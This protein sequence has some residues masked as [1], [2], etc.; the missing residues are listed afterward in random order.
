MKIAYLIAAHSYPSSLKNLVDALLQNKKRSSVFIHID[1]KTEINDF[2]SCC[3]KYDNVQFVEN[4]YYVNWSSFANVLVQIELLKSAL[5]INNFDRFVFLSG[6]DYPVFSND[7]ISEFFQKNDKI[8]FV[9]GAELSSSN[10][11]NVLWRINK[12]HLFRDSKMPCCLRRLMMK[13]ARISQYCFG[14]KKPVK[15]LLGNKSVDVF[16][17][18]DW[19]ALTNKCAQMVL[20]TFKTDSKFVN[21]FKATFCPSEM[22]INTLVY[23][24]IFKPPQFSWNLS[25]PQNIEALTPLHFLKYNH[26]VKPLSLENYEEII[27]S[28]KLFYRKSLPGISDTLNTKIQESWN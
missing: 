1:K 28:K 14:I 16:T 27:K 15:V 5:N 20:D 26:E 18:S 2:I 25:T 19:M 12:Y 23:N 17:G 6:L 7:I 10:H 22:F 24:S 21:Y 11:K 4:R 8:E 13:M 9:G 3:G